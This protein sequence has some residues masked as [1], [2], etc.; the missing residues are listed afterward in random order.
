MPT[1]GHQENGETTEHTALR[2]GREEAGARARLLPLPLPSAFPHPVLTAPWWIMDVPAAPD[3]QT[4]EPHLHRDHVFVEGCL[5]WIALLSVGGLVR[6]SLPPVDAGSFPGC[7]GWHGGR[8]GRR[9][10]AVSQ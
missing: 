10:E 3:N 7:C 1:G 4:G 5:S 8:G 6:A 2:E 9:P